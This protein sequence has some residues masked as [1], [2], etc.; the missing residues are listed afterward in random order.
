MNTDNLVDIKGLDKL[1]VIK[2][3]YFG[4][5]ATGT[6]DTFDKNWENV[7]PSLGFTNKRLDML[8]NVHYDMVFN[9]DEYMQANMVNVFFY[10][11]K[12]GTGLAQQIVEDLRR[13]KN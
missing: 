4:A 7:L 8:G 12:H 1:Q 3:L 11:L 6:L 13:R 10:N 5:I 2:S 9:D